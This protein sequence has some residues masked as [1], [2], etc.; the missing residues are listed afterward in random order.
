MALI[1]P[2]RLSD[3][4]HLRTIGDVLE[5][6]YQIYLKKPTPENKKALD[7][8]AAYYQELDNKINTYDYTND[9]KHHWKIEEMWRKL[10]PNQLSPG[11]G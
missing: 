2:T 5:K 4:E 3:I 7:E 9:D 11:G 1:S 10:T 8:L 6:C